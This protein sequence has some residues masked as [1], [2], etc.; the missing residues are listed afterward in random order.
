VIPSAL[1]IAGSDPSG[2]AGIQADL[3]TFSALKVYGMSVI[4]ALTVQN[5]KSV[6]AVSDVPPKLVG[7]QIDAVVSDIPPKAVKTG[8]LM[9]AEN[10][11][12]VAAKVRQYHLRNL[13]VDPVTVSTSGT[14]L[15]HT[16]AI[17]KLRRDLL[18]AALIVTPN[19]DEA[20]VL[21][22]QEVRTV[23]DMEEAALR[24]HGF[25]AQNVYIKGGHLEG[26][27]V[28]VFFDGDTFTRLFQ[29]RIASQDSHGTG[30]VL[31]AA[32]AAYLARGEPVIAAVRYA[33]EFVTTAIRNG[34]RLGE[35][36]GPCDPVGIR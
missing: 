24:I 33:K 29:E 30:C 35:G 19:L 4:A 6:F 20:R 36:N 28:D 14:P 22:G 3:K 23:E 2:G 27:A 17:D 8:M 32:M 7:E 10:V 1:T 11:A 31:S 16:D 13:V 5:T 34:L 15:L 26:D 25:G 9:T 18:P 12:V 21:T